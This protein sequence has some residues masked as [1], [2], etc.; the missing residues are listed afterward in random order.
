M[1]EVSKLMGLTPCGCKTTGHD[2]GCWL[3]L[4]GTYVNGIKVGPSVPYSQHEDDKVLQ[5]LRA[6]EATNCVPEE[7]R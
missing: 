4:G 2:P 1:S 7:K 3:S 6:P 5:Q